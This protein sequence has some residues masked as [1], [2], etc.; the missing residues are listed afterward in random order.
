[1][2]SSDLG[3]VYKA[4]H[5]QLKQTVAIKTLSGVE[6]TPELVQRFNQEAQLAARLQ[7]PNIVPI[8]NF[9]VEQEIY[10]LV[11]QWV[12]G[13]PL[14]TLLLEKKMSPPQA[15]DIMQQITK[16]ISYA[17]SEGVIHRDLKPSNVM[18][19]RWGRALVLD[20]G[21]AKSTQADSDITRSGQIVGT[22]KY[23][24]PEQAGGKLSEIDAR[25]DVYSMG[26]MLYEMLT[27]KCPFDGESTY[28]IIYKI[29]HVDPVPLHKVN[30]RLHRDL[31][32]I[33]EKAM[34]KEKQMR[35]ADASD[36]QEDILRY[37]HG[38]AILAKPPGLGYRASKWMLRHPTLSGTLALSLFFLLAILSWYI[39][40]YDPHMNLKCMYHQAKTHE[41][42]TILLGTLSSQ[43]GKKDASFLLDVLGKG[44]SQE[45]ALALQMLA[46]LEERVAPERLD[47]FLSSPDDSLVR[48]AMYAIGRY[49]LNQMAPRLESFIS[50]S[51]DWKIR[52]GALEALVQ[53]GSPKC[54]PL[55]IEALNDND[56]VRESAQKMLLRMRERS[57]PLLLNA[58]LGPYNESVWK[59]GHVLR[60]MGSEVV[61]KLFERMR[62]SDKSQKMMIF[63]LAAAIQDP[64]CIRFLA[65]QLL[66]AQEM[67]LERKAYTLF[68][69]L[70]KKY[71]EDRM[72]SDVLSSHH[73]RF[74][75]LLEAQCFGTLNERLPHKVKIFSEGRYFKKPELHILL[76]PH[77]VFKK[78]R[79]EEEQEKKKEKKSETEKVVLPV[80][81]PPPSEGISFSLVG[82]AATHLGCSIELRDEGRVIDTISYFIQI[83][84]ITGLHCNIYDTDDPIALGNQTKY[85]VEVRNEG[86]APLTNLRFLSQVTPEL[87]ILTITLP[88]GKEVQARSQT[89]TEKRFFLVDSPL[90]PGGKIRY[91]VTCKAVKDGSAL[92]ATS[93]TYDQFSREIVLSEGTMVYLK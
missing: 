86:T 3:S 79:E 42:R 36:F 27:G 78:D 90:E 31:Q 88:S 70:Q 68:Q 76:S 53:M 91:I 8:Y 71:P 7:H 56:A 2:C 21:L 9:G 16:A 13:V 37:V 33:V 48:A 82:K 22:P 38:E 17:H 47:D 15:L 14:S 58:F 1:M 69:D 4:T 52:L 85:I 59:A 74:S 25:T 49:S 65:S 87:E 51:Q 18:I 45:Q 67:D 60:I 19:D 11:M 20:F 6:V 54:V 40:G 41:E 89:C 63:K 93:I 83:I 23:M 30:A 61:P 26:V 81:W 34:A 62:T 50:P 75:M 12:D 24:S 46:N 5:H 66:T 28:T 10:Y 29:L 55:C 32:T 35:Y 72:I 44:S 39:F 92:Y 43:A 73:R 57:I 77:L 64:E 84:G 80:P